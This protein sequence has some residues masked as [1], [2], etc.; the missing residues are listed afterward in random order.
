MGARELLKLDKVYAEFIAQKVNDF[1]KRNNI[2]RAEVDLIASHGHTIFHEPEAGFGF[3][4][5]NHPIL[6]KNTN[7][8]VVCDFRRQDLAL[9][10]QGAP[11]VPVG[12]KLL[13]SDFDACLNLGGFAN[14]S[15]Q[16]KDRRLAYDI[17]PANI[18][19]NEFASI[20]GHSFDE[21]GN[22]ARSGKVD[23]EWLKKLNDLDF[24]K[25]QAPK[26]LGLE[27]IE[28]Q[29]KPSLP[30]NAPIENLL[31][32]TVEH[33]SFQIAKAI[34][35]FKTVL[36]TGGGVYNEF[37]LDSLEKKLKN[38]TK[39][40]IPN[41]SLIEHKEALIFGFLGL[42]RFLGQE[43]IYASVTGANK[44]HSSGQIFNP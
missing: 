13:F 19:L 37:L 36:I 24:Y 32:T 31:A 2:S 29:L 42:L 22:L 1:I 5:G 8:M 34:Q 28:K 11:L 38:K 4:L 33:T 14:V 21:N 20:L 12:D 30:R 17:C 43:N 3:Q 44:N 25:K 9:G 41:A 7:C 27:W 23:H 35:S 26:S 6:A 40:K 10:G 39:I 18:L 16:S 15:F